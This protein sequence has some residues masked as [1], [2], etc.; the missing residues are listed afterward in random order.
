MFF[1]WDSEQTYGLT[2]GIDPARA[3]RLGSVVDVLRSGKA[4][5]PRLWRAL[6][7]GDDF[8]LELADRVYR[9]T[10]YDGPLEELR[11]LSRSGRG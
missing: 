3:R 11:L 7:E 10:H 4:P 2:A 8:R 1:A 5:I 6:V 9:A